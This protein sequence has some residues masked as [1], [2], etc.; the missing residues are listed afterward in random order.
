L[1]ITDIGRLTLIIL[2]LDNELILSLHQLTTLV[3]EN[4]GEL[5]YGSCRD[6]FE[7]GKTDFVAVASSQNKDEGQQDCIESFHKRSP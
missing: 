1:H 7:R 6:W 2:E 3:R 4:D 5:A